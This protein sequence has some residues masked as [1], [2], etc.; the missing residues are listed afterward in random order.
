MLINFV[1]LV[2]RY[3][4]KPNGLIQF[5]AHYFE[6]KEIFIE[7]GFNDFILVEAQERCIEKINE[8]IIGVNATVLNIAVSDKLT[9]KS[10]FVDSNNEGQSASI[11]KPLLHEK[12]Y[13]EIR[14]DKNERV[15][16]VPFGYIDIDSK[17]NVLVMDIQGNELRALQGMGTDQV[18]QL[19]AIFT[20]V[21]IIELYE[22][23]CLLTDLD[24]YLLHKGFFRFETILNE[25]G[26]GDALYLRHDN[27][28]R[29][30]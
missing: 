25:R 30:K 4:I 27:K 5:G 10:M 21:N 6:E 14:F 2:R 1:E 20:E 29:N 17:Y 28:K 26:H 8:R 7:A 9:S 11:L 3:K 13:P 12:E 22:N 24:H 15:M 18:S 16:V 19:D 23:C